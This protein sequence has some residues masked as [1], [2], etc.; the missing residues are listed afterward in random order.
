M[1][2][3]DPLVWM[4]AAYALFM[5]GV[6][7]GIDKLG[8]RSAERS[9]SWRTGNFVYH[10]DHDAW[11][12]HEDQWLW[13]A[14]FDPDKRVIRYVGQ[15]AVCGRCPV[16]EACSPTPGPREITKQLDP[17]PFSEAGRFQRGIALLVAVIGIFLPLAMLIAAHEVLDLV[18][19][20]T[21]VV[22]VGAAGVYPLARHLWNSPANFPEHLPAE[23]MADTAASQPQQPSAEELIDRYSTRWSSDRRRVGKD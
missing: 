4:V 16:K 9:A 8:R 3:P 14:S 6:A 12:C 1:A 19:L 20:G 7:W 2:L 13:P 5:L 17:W 15:H 18:V 10:E 23:G 21:T 22:V 11:Q